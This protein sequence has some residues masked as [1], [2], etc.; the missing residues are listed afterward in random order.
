MRMDQ[1]RELSWM[2][3]CMTCFNVRLIAKDRIGGM[4]G[5]GEREDGRR[6]V[7]GRGFSAKER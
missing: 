1:E 6:N 3:V 7:I 2:F 5:A 4:K